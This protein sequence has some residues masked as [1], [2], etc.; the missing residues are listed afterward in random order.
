[1]HDSRQHYETLL[2]PIYAWSRGG[3]AAAMSATARLVDQCGLPAGARVLDLGAGFGAA[4]VPLA[5]RHQ[6]R[7][8]D[9]SPA[10]LA[11][12]RAH[13]AAAGVAVEVVEADLVAHLEAQTETFGGVLCLGD[14]LPHLAGLADVERAVAGVARALAPDGVAV[15]GYRAA[16]EARD[17]GRFI[18]VH[19]DAQRTLTCFLERLDGARQIVWDIVHERDGEATRMHV[20][21]YPK[22]LL[23]PDW[24]AVVAAQHG[25]ASE[26]LPPIDGMTI[27]LFKKY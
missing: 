18:L 27:Q 6:V 7:A 11:E 24:V 1:M 20:S 13:A 25:L 4:A 17:A 19:G 2:A 26:T 8:V 12:L 21:S 22:L 9:N 5:R 14:T 3:A 23:S 10:L 15:F 16:T